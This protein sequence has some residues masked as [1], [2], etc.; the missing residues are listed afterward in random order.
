M[1]INVPFTGTDTHSPKRCSSTHTYNIYTYNI[2]SP[3]HLQKTEF[4]IA[5]DSS[6][7][8]SWAG[9]HEDKHTKQSYSNRQSGSELQ[10][11]HSML[12]LSKGTYLDAHVHAR[13][14][15]VHVQAGN[16]GLHDSLG[17]AL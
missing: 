6:S 11:A 2:E 15:Q 4:C 8:Q 9:S 13:F 7:V 12:Q 3:H 5:T 17:H 16:F 1:H 10:Y 14:L